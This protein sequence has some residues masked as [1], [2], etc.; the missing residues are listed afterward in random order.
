MVIAYVYSL[1]WEFQD[2]TINLKCAMRFDDA[3]PQI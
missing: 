1:Y 2:K 3:I